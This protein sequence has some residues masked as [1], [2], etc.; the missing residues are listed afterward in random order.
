MREYYL[1]VAGFTILLSFYPTEHK[2]FQDLLI[3][4]VINFWGKGG[5]LSKKPR[6]KVA[7][8]IKILPF[9]KLIKLIGR[10]G[11]ERYHNTYKFGNRVLEFYYYISFP[12]LQMVFKQLLY[13]LIKKDGF[14]LHASSVLDKNRNLIVFLAPQ[15]GGKSTS[16]NLMTKFKGFSKFDDDNLLVRKI[17]GGWKFFSPPFIEKEMNPIKKIAD[18]AT[19]FFVKKAKEMNKLSIQKTKILPLLL[20]QIWVAN[21]GIERQTFENTIKFVEENNFFI[22]HAN[23]KAKELKNTLYGN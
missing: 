4:N 16:A 6:G 23:L 12:L 14:I 15:G 18:K 13:E 10:K 20:K 3:E 7:Y 19:F 5:F 11:G 8:T 17:G 1:E 2:I 22:L 9:P 21:K